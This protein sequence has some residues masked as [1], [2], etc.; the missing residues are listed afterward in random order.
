MSYDATVYGWAGVRRFSRPVWEGR[1]INIIPGG[2]LTP[3]RSSFFNL[4]IKSSLMNHV[5]E[6]VLFNRMFHSIMIIFLMEYWFC[7]NYLLK[8]IDGP[9]MAVTKLFSSCKSSAN[10]KGYGAVVHCMRNL[11][12]ES[13]IQVILISLCLWCVIYPCLDKYP[14]ADY[15]PGGSKSLGFW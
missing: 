13:Q 14:I 12:S 1:L 11:P 9:E 10:M 15:C 4:L 5:V 6:R 8:G 7:L 3:H 2:C